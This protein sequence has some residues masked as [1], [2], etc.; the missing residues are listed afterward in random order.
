[1]PDTAVKVDT[2]AEMDPAT[3]Q[4]LL[5]SGRDTFE[6]APTDPRLHAAVDAALRADVQRIRDYA[7]VNPDDEFV[8]ANEHLLLKER[9]SI[10]RFQSAASVQAAVAS[11][12][13]ETWTCGGSANMSGFVWWA[14]GGTVMFAPP[15][16][17]LFG[18]S[19]GPDWALSTFTSG[20][21]GSFVV[22]PQKI[23]DTEMHPEDS[24]VGTVFKGKC[25]FQLSQ[26][27]AGAGGIRISF[28][29]TNGTYWGL[30]GGVTAGLGGA[31]VSGECDLAWS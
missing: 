13:L 9:P 11:S 7:A 5:S 29:S 8:K 14:L 20:I 23:R 30:L 27:G 2:L 19:G 16:G 17:F 21:A 4:E 1:M 25:R 15:L 28:Y 26:G 3:V 31:S 24:G 6:A 10:R 18:A 22:D 12:A